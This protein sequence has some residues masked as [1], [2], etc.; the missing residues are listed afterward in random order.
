MAKWS[1]GI[2]ERRG[3]TSD[4][5]EAVGK[6]EESMLRMPGE[7]DRVSCKLR[8]VCKISGHSPKR[9]GHDQGKQEKALSNLLEL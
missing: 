6:D 3:A 2:T 9:S 8:K 5:V 1:D 7:A 4:A